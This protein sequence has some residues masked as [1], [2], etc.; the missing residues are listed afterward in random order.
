M[1][2]FIYIFIAIFFIGCC[3]PKLQKTGNEDIN[4]IENNSSINTSPYAITINQADGTS[5][6]IIGKGTRQNPY[7]ETTDGYTVLKN[8]RSIY[9]Y[10]GMRKD[11]KL[12]LSGIKARNPSERTKK[13]K[14]FL[15]SINK[16]LRDKQK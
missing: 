4:N 11:G 5:I 2:N 16:H 1:N 6:D 14:E 15:N 3:S 10:A 8:E 13:E 9:E 7:S 12:S